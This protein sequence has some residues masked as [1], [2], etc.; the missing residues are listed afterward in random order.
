M[1]RSS[2]PPAASSSPGCVCFDDDERHHRHHLLRWGLA[3]AAAVIG[4]VL[5]RGCDVARA[6]DDPLAAPLS[7]ELARA[8][9]AVDCGRDVDRGAEASRV[10]P[11]L[12]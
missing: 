1:Y 6:R 11:R 7:R 3:A 12:S 9:A 2:R 8:R 4:T 5:G 10:R